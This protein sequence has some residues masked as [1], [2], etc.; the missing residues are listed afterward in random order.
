MIMER[1][2]LSQLS[3]KI[4]R[5]KK[6]KRLLEAFQTNKLYSIN[7][8]KLKEE[9]M[10]LHQSRNVRTLVKFREDRQS[11]MVDEVIH[12]N[13]VDQGQRSRLTEILIQCTRASCAL[14]DA[15][16]V[17]KEYALIYYDQHLNR[18]KTKGERSTFLDTC[19]SDMQGYI[20]DCDLVINLA[21]IVIADVDAAGWSLTRTINA[22]SLTQAG[23]RKI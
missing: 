21:K 13:L 2:T 1:L 6:Y 9:I 11:K 7:L 4:H 8:E 3:D 16:K 17:F 12:A 22:L 18:I 10:T 19:L 14:N 20:N 15:L 5:N 23:E